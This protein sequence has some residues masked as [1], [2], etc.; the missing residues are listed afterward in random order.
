MKTVLI[1]TPYRDEFTV[2]YLNGMIAAMTDSSLAK[3]YRFVPTVTSSTYVQIARNEIANKAVAMNADEVVFVDADI[4]WVPQQLATLLRH[5]VDIV[6]ADYC[7]R[8]P[9]EPQG[10]AR[11][12]PGSVPRADGL[13]VATCL[14]GGFLRIRTSVFKEMAARLPQRWYR[15]GNND[16]ACEF[17]PVALTEKNG[18]RHPAEAVLDSIWE[19]TAN[20]DQFEDNAAKVAEVQR[21]IAAHGSGID[22]GPLPE[23]AG[24]DVAFC[25]LATECGFTVWCDVSIRLR[26]YGMIGFPATETPI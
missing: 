2:R 18:W 20:D 3:E 9:G 5:D 15:H 14:P 16:A 6:G 11:A 8:I 22:L 10:C 19:V 13:Q 4:G 7:K 21:L 1:G 17:F 12:L 23:I 24:E 26:H 25:R